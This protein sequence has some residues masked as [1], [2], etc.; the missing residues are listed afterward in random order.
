METSVR[1][2]IT[3]VVYAAI[4]DLNEGLPDGERVAKA[5]DVI[6]LG[7]SGRLDSLG[8]VNLVVAIEQKLQE[9]L[10]A[11]V[12]LAESLMQDDVQG[13][14]ATVHDMVEHIELLMEKQ[15]G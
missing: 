13:L 1:D 5:P 4:D 14:P 12:G 11:S 10:S 9:R 8:F 15:A 6:L 3:G 7:E 2:Q